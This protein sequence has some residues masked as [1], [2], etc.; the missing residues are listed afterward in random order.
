MRGEYFVPVTLALEKN[1]GARIVLGG[2]ASYIQRSENPGDCFSSAMT[3][4]LMEATSTEGH[5][6]KMSQVK[7]EKRKSK[8][9]NQKRKNSPT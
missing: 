7:N 3:T 9:K 5:K 2:M 6:V 1:L 4:S 8:I